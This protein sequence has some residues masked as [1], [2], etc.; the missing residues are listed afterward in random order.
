MKTY[1][2][3]SFDV[4]GNERDG[5]EINNIF[6]TDFR[7]EIEDNATDKEVI[8]I[9]SYAGFVKPRYK[10]NIE[11]NDETLAFVTRPN[12]FPICNLVLI[13]N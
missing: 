6:N 2:I 4:W 7:I 3:Q 10:F 1:K 13:E 5:F 9:L 11:W 12:G 8:K